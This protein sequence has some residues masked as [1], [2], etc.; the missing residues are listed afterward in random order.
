LRARHDRRVRSDDS[1][2]IA[3]LIIDRTLASPEQ[4]QTERRRKP[5]H[6]NYNFTFY[7][8]PPRPPSR[9]SD[10]GRATEESTE[11]WMG[12]WKELAIRFISVSDARVVRIEEN[13]TR[14]SVE[15]PR[16]RKRELTRTESAFQ[17]SLRMLAKI[18]SS[19][20]TPKARSLIEGKSAL[21][22]RAIQN[23]KKICQ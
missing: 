9:S 23:T 14:I 12:D 21:I 5:F 8:F 18:A 10:P 16:R 2:S 20:H 7:T 1:L 6:N 11:P 13:E 17:R 22:K 4:R 19:K 15:I 3:P